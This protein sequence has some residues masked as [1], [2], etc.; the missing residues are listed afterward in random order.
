MSWNISL[1]VFADEI[2]RDF[3]EQLSVL[4]SKGLSQLDLRGAWGK[5]VLDFTDED[6][7]QIKKLLQEHGVSVAC[8]GSPIGKTKITDSFDDQI[9]R[10]R[11]A[12]EIARTVGT[13]NIRIFSFYLPVGEPPEHYRDEVMRRLQLLTDLASREAPEIVLL[14]ENER[15]IYGEN[16]ERCADIFHSVSAANLRAVFDPANF[17]VVKVRP[18]SEAWPL[19]EQFVAYLHIKDA[20]WEEGRI[21]PA[22]VGDGELR[23]VLTALYRRSYAG[24]L[25]LEPHL[26]VAA[27]SHG[28]T[29]PEQ[30]SV[31][32]KAL[33]NLIQDVEGGIQA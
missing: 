18:Y 10:F 21:V 26:R 11:R 25:A 6:V 33:R 29:G 22:G 20:L 13:P 12:I 8:I 9:P 17:V 7:A 2:A 14:H 4:R 16:G 15:E 24:V 32:V 28:W 1:S 23:E 3:A 5:N 19:L 31:A 30:F 27:R